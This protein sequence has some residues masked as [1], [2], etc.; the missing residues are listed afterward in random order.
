MLVAAIAQQVVGW[1]W[2][3][4]FDMAAVRLAKRV[5]PSREL[6][7]VTDKL[8][9]RG[10]II[11]IC[12]P[13]ML[14]VSRRSRNWAPITGFMLVFLFETGMAGSLKM[15]VGR[16]FPYQKEMALGTESLAFPSGH[17]ANAFALWG[18]IAWY[19]AERRKDLRT[20]IY[21]LFVVALGIVGASSWLLRTHWPTDLIAGFALGAIALFAVVGALTALDLNPSATPRRLREGPRENQGVR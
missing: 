20:L 6:L 17:A 14:V 2:L 15:A 8:G 13:W 11:S 18:F 21:G 16:T 9:L 19:L 12:I 1:G 4:D 10:L 5:A 7:L 3:V